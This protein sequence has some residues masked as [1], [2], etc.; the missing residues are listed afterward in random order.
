MAMDRMGAFLSGRVSLEMIVK[1]A[2]ARLALVA[3]VSAASARAV[4]AADRLGITLCGFV[5]GNEI[6]VYTHDRRILA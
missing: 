6:A 3:A 4:E 1:A 5:R 2:R